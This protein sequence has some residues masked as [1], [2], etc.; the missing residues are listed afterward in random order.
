MIQCTTPSPVIN[1]WLLGDAYVYGPLYIIRIT[2]I[3]IAITIITII[4]I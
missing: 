1:E 4:T 2:I 3:M